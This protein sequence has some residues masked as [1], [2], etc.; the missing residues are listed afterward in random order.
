MPTFGYSK[1]WRCRQVLNTMPVCRQKWD[2]EE[3]IDV[4]IVKTVEVAE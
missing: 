1:R 3:D 2:I 4:E